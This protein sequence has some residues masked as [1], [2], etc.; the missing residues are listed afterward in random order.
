MCAC[1][2]TGFRIYYPV[3]ACSNPLRIAYL[4]LGNLFPPYGDPDKNNIQMRFFDTVMD[5]VLME[6]A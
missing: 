6:R 4:S 1:L 5:T 3:I 2:I